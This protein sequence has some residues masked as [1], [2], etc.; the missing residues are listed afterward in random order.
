[1]SYC[2]CCDVAVLDWSLIV[3]IMKP[4]GHAVLRLDWPGHYLLT[5][6]FR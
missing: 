2:A 3:F 4:Q 5:F 1:L 6:Q